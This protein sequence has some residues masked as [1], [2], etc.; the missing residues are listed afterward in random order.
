ML[1]PL[2]RGPLI[3]RNRHK[4]P[5]GTGLQATCAA[6]FSGSFGDE[7]QT[8]FS[9]PTALG[10]Y[11]VRGCQVT[12]KCPPNGAKCKV[13]LRHCGRRN[14]PAA[15]LFGTTGPTRTRVDQAL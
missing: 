7:S 14:V 5:G 10:G 3:V 8:R 12:E 4:V 15:V 6:C 13:C 2:A 11:R 1:C 9:P